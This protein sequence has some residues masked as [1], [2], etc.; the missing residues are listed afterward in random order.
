MVDRR[1][2]EPLRK[3]T[4]GRPVAPSVDAVPEAFPIGSVFIAV[5]AT[6]PSSLLGYGTWS[7]FGA[8]RVMV[9]LD[10][11]DTAFDTAEETGGAKTVASAGT[12]A[13]PTLSGATANE[14]AH[15]HGYTQVLNHTHGVTITDPTHK[16]DVVISAGWG[17]PGDR[18]VA[19][20]DTD[21]DTTVASAASNEATGITASTGNPSGGVASGTTAAGSAHSHG[22]GTLAA[23]A[24]A[25]TG[26]ATSVLQP[27]IV[28]Y[29]WKRVS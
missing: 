7:A 27:Y 9:G 17:G 18:A 1:W 28:A 20:S 25:F 22:A 21:A 6:N 29:F 23:S 14:S 5:V 12:V 26:S 10:S 24:P 19:G 8:G 2:R 11:G 4:Y 15:T 16:H 3:T 13:A